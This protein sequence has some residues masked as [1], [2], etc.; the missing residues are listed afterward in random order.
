MHKPVGTCEDPRVPPLVLALL[1]SV[2]ALAFHHHQRAQ[3]KLLPDYEAASVRAEVRG[4]ELG[5]PA[6]GGLEIR[7]VV[8]LEPR[9]EEREVSE[10]SVRFHVDLQLER[11]LALELQLAELPLDRS[12]FALLL[13]ELEAWCYARIPML[14]ES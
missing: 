6:S 1:D 8:T 9:G 12:G 13:G 3:R 2:F 4:P 10:E 11:L 5:E 7:V 14:P